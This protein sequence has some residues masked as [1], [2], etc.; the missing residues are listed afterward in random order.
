MEASAL[1]LDGPSELPGL[2][3][4]DKAFIGPCPNHGEAQ[5]RARGFGKAAVCGG[6]LQFLKVC[7]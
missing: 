1:R 4:A 3:G 6:A 2:Q 7:R 5:G